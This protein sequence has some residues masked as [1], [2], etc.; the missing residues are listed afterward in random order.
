MYFYTLS[1]K[2]QIRH[3]IAI[4]LY[5]NTQLSSHELM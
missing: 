2:M 4:Q 5:K 1:T 3:T